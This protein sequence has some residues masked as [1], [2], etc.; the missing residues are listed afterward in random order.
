MAKPRI[1][2]GFG[3]FGEILWF[4]KRFRIPLFELILQVFF[5]QHSV[6]C[7]LVEAP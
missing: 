3:V 6:Q 7:I 5:S 4:K 1:F 2:R